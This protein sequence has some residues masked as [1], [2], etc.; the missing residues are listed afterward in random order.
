VCPSFCAHVRV[1]LLKSFFIYINPLRIYLQSVTLLVH[2]WFK[3]LHA[4]TIH[5]TECKLPTRFLGLRPFGKVIIYQFFWLVWPVELTQH[6]W[7]EATKT[8]QIQCLVLRVREKIQSKLCDLG[9]TTIFINM[10]LRE[11]CIELTKV[12]RLYETP[13]LIF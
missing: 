9:I 5:N 2:G 7:N 3:T 10:S 6:P 11:F 12:C 8:Q 1:C 4:W 13:F